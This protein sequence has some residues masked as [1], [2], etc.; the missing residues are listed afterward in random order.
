MGTVTL[1]IQDTCVRITPMERT[2]LVLM[3]MPFVA[4]TK[5]DVSVEV[6]GSIHGAFRRAKDAGILCDELNTM[7][8]AEGA[9]IVV[10]LEDIR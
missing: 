9:F 3:G 7:Y 2:Q 5:K 10:N 4:V 6:P 1:I 8:N